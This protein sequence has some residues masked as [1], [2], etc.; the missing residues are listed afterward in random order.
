M[1]SYLLNAHDGDM[2]RWREAAKL[3]RLPFSA[4]LRQAADSFAATA[5]SQAA[6]RPPVTTIALPG[7]MALQP[8]KRRPARRRPHR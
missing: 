2:E 4:W 3:R 7:H 8:Q 1:A 5:P 6:P